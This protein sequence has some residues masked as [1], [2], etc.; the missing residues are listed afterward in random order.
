MKL[1]PGFRL[2]ALGVLTALVIGPA[3]YG[4]QPSPVQNLLTRAS[5]EFPGKAGIW[6]KHL[7]TGETAGVRD[8]ELFNSASTLFIRLGKTNVS[9]PAE[10]TRD[11]GPL[12][13]V[14]RRK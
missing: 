3:V 8:G 7:A 13:S 11:L 9:P 6:V 12:R 1:S 5:N 10:Y 4:R 2:S 14:S